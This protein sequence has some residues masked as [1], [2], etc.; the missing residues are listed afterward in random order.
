MHIQ[1]GEQI[2]DLGVKEFD[3]E[4]T[5]EALSVVR[6]WKSQI[7]PDTTAF[8]TRDERNWINFSWETFRLQ[9]KVPKGYNGTSR[10]VSVMC[11]DLPLVNQ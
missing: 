1:S 11:N 9:T 3:A 8:L 10:V 2:I 5:K 7:I 4:H 6:E